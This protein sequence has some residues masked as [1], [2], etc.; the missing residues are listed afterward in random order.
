MRPSRVLFRLMFTVAIAIAM[1]PLPATATTQ[2]QLQREI[3]ALEKRISELEMNTEVNSALAD[4]IEQRMGQKALLSGYID[5][6][7]ISSSKENANDHFR[8]RQLDPPR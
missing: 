4:D 3:E 2:E 1:V 6:E 8:N 5:S 7:F